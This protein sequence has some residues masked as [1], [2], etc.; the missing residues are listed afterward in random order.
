[1][2]NAFDFKRCCPRIRMPRDDETRRGFGPR[3]IG[4]RARI[5]GARIDEMVN[6]LRGKAAVEFHDHHPTP[7]AL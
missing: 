1:M 6:R 2:H 3:I 7:L 5:A 4:N